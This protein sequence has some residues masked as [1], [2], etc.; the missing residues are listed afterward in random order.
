MRP[1]AGCRL[2]LGLLAPLVLLLPACGS[3]SRVEHYPIQVRFIDFP[4]TLVAGAL[5]TLH[6]G[7]IVGFDRCE[8]EDLRLA[9]QHDSLI[10]RGTARCRIVEVPESP[11]VSPNGQWLELAL[12]PLAAG[13]YLVIGDDLVDTLI[14]VAA[15]SSA[16][17]RRIAAHGSLSPYVTGSC[18]AETWSFSPANADGWAPGSW[19]AY[20]LNES[21]PMPEP[22]PDDWEVHALVL[23]PPT[24]EPGRFTS[25]WKLR[26][27]RVH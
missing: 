6:L 11:P 23:G 27:F 1:P 4:D 20:Q 7:A 10:V 22:W 18:S 25:R 14:V 21:L 13:R 5:D 24:C 16:P 19:R 8:L 15:A 3:D 2:L 9:L 12:P 26:W 17:R